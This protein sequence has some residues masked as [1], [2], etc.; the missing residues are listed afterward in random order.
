MLVGKAVP[1]DQ[2]DSRSSTEQTEFLRE[3]PAPVVRKG[4]VRRGQDP[5]ESASPGMREEQGETP[6]E[7]TSWV[8][9]W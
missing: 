7:T 3:V 8:S 6:A 5:L 9:R 1:F 2:R 4:A